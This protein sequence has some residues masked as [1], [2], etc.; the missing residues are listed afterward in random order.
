MPFLCR[1]KNDNPL[2]IHRLPFSEVPQFSSR[3]RAYVAEEAALRPFYL[4]PPALEQFAE[5]I[6]IRETHQPD[7]QTLVEVLK[8]QYSNRPKHEEALRAIDALADEQTFTVTTAHQPSLFTGP[9]YY[10]YKI[11]STIHLARRLQEA[12]PDHRFV[13][14]F[15]SGGEDHDFEE[16][17]HAHLFGKT[18]RWEQ[19]RGGPVGQLPTESLAR[20]L[21]ELK[22]ILGERDAAQELYEAIREAYTGNE[23]YGEAAAH[24]AAGL[25]G[26]YGLVVLDMSDARLKRLFIPH[27]RKE[28]LE[29]PSRA[30]VQTA[31]DQLEKAGFSGQAHAREINLFYLG[32]GYRER[33][34]Y[35]DGRYQVLNQDIQWTEEELLAEL[36]RAPERFSPNVVMRPLYQEFI[37]PNLAYI[38]GGGELAYWLERKAQFEHFGIP[39]PMLVRRNS[40]LWIDRTTAKKMDKVGLSIPDLFEDTEVLVKR[41]VRKHT[42]NELS[43]KEEKKA[44][45]Q[46]LDQVV[47]KAREIDPTLVK[48]TKGE[49]TKMLN[50][51]NALEAKLIR[52]EKNNHDIAI[53]Q[54]RS[55]KERLFPGDGLQER[56]DN[57]MTFYLRYGEEFM[58][59]LL[60]ELDPLRKEMI[61]VYDG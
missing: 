11:V 37:L 55:V 14:V 23:K 31:Q 20:P 7:R 54:I 53:N 12:Y 48:S 41:Y 59:T 5:V 38:G 22:E 47:E 35:T 42:E 26:S 49:G 27:F 60:R 15:I 8:D 56:H 43:L 9:L 18:I 45:Q 57:F 17:N 50:G 52:A 24:L 58:E 30:L 44:I 21:Q 25:F 34:E 28:L 61:V 19:D 10:I 33:I 32:P 2:E 29:R 46:L 51:L 39:Y 3:D 1:H 4:H 6:A 13:P 16:I 36:E 40:V